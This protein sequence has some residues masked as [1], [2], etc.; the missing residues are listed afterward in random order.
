MSNGSVDLRKGS[1]VRG[2]WNH[3]SVICLFCHFC[4]SSFLSYTQVTTRASEVVF[5]FPFYPYK[6]ISVQPKGY[7]LVHKLN[8][9]LLLKICRHISA[10]G[11]IST[12]LTI[13]YQEQSSSCFS[14]SSRFAFLHPKT[15]HVFSKSVA[16][17][18]CSV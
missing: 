13:V 16:S 9:T 8:V 11:L 1:Q 15:H 3:G 6:A 17:L 10:L 5:L 7:F 14:H 12:F 2:Y 4:L 18:N